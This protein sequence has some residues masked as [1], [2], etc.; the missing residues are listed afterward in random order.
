MKRI[1]V[2][3]FLIL[4][5]SI[6]IPANSETL[7]AGI[8]KLA[9]KIV[10]NSSINGKRSIAISYFTHTNGDTSEF[11]KYIAD[12]LVVNLFNVP[13][14]N[15]DIIE[16]EQL[17]AIFH[18]MKFNMT[19]V[20][21]TK[22][23]QK[24]GK[25]HGVDSLVLG[26]I[27]EMGKKISITARVADTE[28]GQVTSAAEV[29]IEKKPYIKNLLSKKII[30]KDAHETKKKSE[31]KIKKTS[32]SREKRALRVNQ[33][34]I[35]LFKVIQ[36]YADNN[37]QV[38]ILPTQEMYKIGRDYLE[39]TVSSSRSGYLT[40]LSVG[41]SKKIYQLFPNK[42]DTDNSLR[43]GRD[44]FLPR[45]SWR[46]PA[47]GPAGIDYFLA[48]VTNTPNPFYGLGV[49]AGPFIKLDKNISTADSLIE[50]MTSCSQ[51]ISSVNKAECSQSSERDFG[52]IGTDSSYCSSSQ[53]DFD[54][55]SVNKE[56]TKNYAVGFMQVREIK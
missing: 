13:N 20:V 51:S 28:T 49:P 44:I 15:L 1:I 16:R 22:T 12:K 54:A 52:A 25:I 37:I 7:Q 18:E 9:Q 47:N 35:E 3:I 41:S 31:K 14:A 5:F 53:R 56:C 36:Q 32:I 2:G 17:A 11:S 48:I 34:P 4:Q 27:T 46:L 38:S 8:K 10:S 24:L 21:D 29:I 45:S 26:S 55:I 19:G 42:L 6:L 50:S 43:P 40:I 30:D 39:M 33:S 23:I